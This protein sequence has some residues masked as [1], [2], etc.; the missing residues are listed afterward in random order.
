MTGVIHR[1]NPVVVAQQVA[2]LEA[3][4]PG[5][6]FLG[7]GSSEAMNEVPA[8]MA[9]PDTGEQLARTEE[10]LS[11]IARLLDGETVTHDGPHFRTV[12]ARL[13][14]LPERRPPIVV[15]AF[16]EQMAEVAG[17]LADGLWTLANPLTTPK[18]IAA[19]RRG[20]EEAGR[21]PGEIF[22]QALASVAATD[23]EALEAPGSGSRASLRRSTPTTSTRPRTSRAVARRSPTAPSRGRTSYRPTRRRTWR[24]SACSP[25]SARRP[26]SW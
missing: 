12:G 13:Y 3:L 6:A 10:A 18:I 24:S 20:A 23:E 19:Y 16:H 26:S 17:R 9:W 15:S 11:I 25:S 1:Y 8:G 21:E 7:V 4:A 14:G 5:R 22:L 2:T